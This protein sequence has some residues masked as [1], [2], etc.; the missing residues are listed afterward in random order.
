MLA[1]VRVTQRNFVNIAVY[2]D[3]KKFVEIFSDF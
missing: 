3:E 1:V 2:N